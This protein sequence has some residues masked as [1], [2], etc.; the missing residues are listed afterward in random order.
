MIFL[1][2]VLDGKSTLRIQ[3]MS[4]QRFPSG[5]KIKE[6]FFVSCEKSIR[7][8]YP[9]GTIFA[10]TSLLDKGKFYAADDLKIYPVESTV[11]IKSD[12]LKGSLDEYRRYKESVG[13]S[14]IVE[15]DNDVPTQPEV[16]EPVRVKSVYE[17]LK[18]KLNLRPPTIEDDGF[19]VD[20]EL[21]YLLLRNLRNRQNT[22]LKGPT[23]SGKTEIVYFLSKVANKELFVY[24]MGSMHDP[25]TGLLGCHRI[26][27]SG[28]SEFD[29]SKFS[30][31]ITQP[32][33]LL[34]D[35][36]SRAPL[37]TNNILLP[38]L[39]SRRE[40]PVHIAASSG[41]RNV[42]VDPDLTFFATANLGNEYSGTNE[43]DRAL[44]DRFFPVELSYMPKKIEAEVL[45]ARTGVGKSEAM[46]I[47]TIAETIRSLWEKGELSTAISTR[48]TLEVAQLV[49]DGFS[50]LKSLELVVL[51]SF[52]GTRLTGER[53][54]VSTIIVSK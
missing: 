17:R 5:A 51:T 50:L 30:Q 44:S 1:I 41:V 21:W 38:C 15:D 47:A 3:P 20:E 31:D 7:A 29:Y 45:S 2:S 23:G 19:Y 16:E 8:E 24:D 26:N 52:T 32:G 35:E 36:L 22:L 33:M 12:T 53:A 40:L 39:D 4:G 13:G 18:S 49:K 54:V 14:F 11:T 37:S 48:V 28:F 6:H 34:L 9:I 25:M 46:M 43:L 10:C 27:A 42:L